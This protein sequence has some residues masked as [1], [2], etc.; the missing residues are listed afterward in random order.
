MSNNLNPFE[1]TKRTNLAIFV[2]IAIILVYSQLMLPQAP[3]PGSIPGQPQATQEQ[4]A[5][6][7]AAQGN[8]AVPVVTTPAGTPTLNL[9]N[10]AQVSAT[11]TA[12]P[13]PA[14]VAAAQSL[15]VNTPL[16]TAKLTL[17]GGRLTSFTLNKHLKELGKQE[18]LELVTTTAENGALPLGIITGGV[19]DNKVTYACLLYTSPSPRD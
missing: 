11:N 5:T 12:P 4:Q 2:C 9:E 7:T 13:T 14:D 15:V 17:L 3:V 18:P 6:G 16:Y 8:V 1:D 10:Q 19:N